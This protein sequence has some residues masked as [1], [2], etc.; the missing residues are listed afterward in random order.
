MSTSPSLTGYS[1]KSPR[2]YLSPNVGLPI[3]VTRTRE[4][5]GADIKQPET[6]KYYGF[7]TFWLIGKDPTTGTWGD[8]WY[9][10][11]IENNVAVWKQIAV[12]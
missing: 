10:A 12:V 7:G 8:M 9:L 3:I 6:G 1:P 5:T 2:R 4:P 11:Y